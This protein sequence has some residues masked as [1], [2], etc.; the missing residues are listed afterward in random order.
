MT[1]VVFVTCL[2]YVR[3][4]AASA[5]L[6]A[7][8]RGEHLPAMSGSLT[9]SGL[10]RPWSPVWAPCTQW[11]WTQRIRHNFPETWRDRQ[12]HRRP[13]SVTA[14]RGGNMQFIFT[15]TLIQ[16]CRLDFKKKEK[17]KR[18]ALLGDTWQKG[19]DSGASH[20][21]TWKHWENF[22][23][24]LFILWFL[25]CLCWPQ[26]NNTSHIFTDLIDLMGT[27][28][29]W[30]WHTGLRGGSLKRRATAI[31]AHSLLEGYS[32]VPWPSCSDN[33]YSCVIQC[34]RAM[35]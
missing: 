16:M 18:F 22:Q 2:Q 29:V 6:Y 19:W 10:W 21:W 13:N 1:S 3:T 27:L 11:S 25:S 4:H 17:K 14:T 33:I 7:A 15:S 34:I 30:L 23:L 8:H 24:I 28:M 20:T 9:L 32:S 31:P 12:R 5:L 35:M 26:N